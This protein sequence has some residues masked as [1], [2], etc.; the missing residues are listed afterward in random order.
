MTGT[1]KSRTLAALFAAAVLAM[2]LVHG[3]GQRRPG[4][5]DL[6]L[7]PQTNAGHWHG[8]WVYKS[9][10]QRIVLWLREDESGKPEYRMQYQSTSTPEA[11][12]TDWAGRADYAVA[13]TDAVFHLAA[14]ER[15]A[16]TIQGTLEWDLQFEKGGRKRAG[17][18]LIYRGGA[19][20]HLVIHFHEQSLTV[21]KG[22]KEATENSSSAWT[23][24]KYSKRLVLWEEIF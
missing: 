8:T 14:T 3:A 23:F 13:G 11:F 7:T 9:R 17:K 6:R 21:R 20:R 24:I 1:Q 2:S 10:Q 22:D 4:V 5:S 16:D 18:F 12:I 19:G 15:D